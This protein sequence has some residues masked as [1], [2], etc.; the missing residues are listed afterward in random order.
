MPTAA[1]T[2]VVVSTA[3][4]TVIRGNYV[5]VNANGDAVISNG[6]SAIGSSSPDVTIGRRSETPIFHVAQEASLVDRVDHA[7]AHRSGDGAAVSVPPNGKHSV[8]ERTRITRSAVE[9]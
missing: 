4:G 5:G 2:H 1:I 3:A 7:D 8:R 6:F 9:L